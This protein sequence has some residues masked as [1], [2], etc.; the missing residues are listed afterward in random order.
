MKFVDRWFEQSTRFVARR[1]SRRNVLTRL[2]A[3]LL[4]STVLPT[5]PVARGEDKPSLPAPVDPDVSD[6]AG[7]PLG[8]NYW[9]HCAIDGYLCGCCGG[10]HSSCPPG[11]EMSPITWIGTCRNP[12]DGL[13]YIISYNDCC[14][15]STCNRCFCG[16]SEGEKPV[17]YAPKSANINWCI[18]T[19]TNIYH[20]STSVVIGRAV[21]SP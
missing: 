14:G 15:K 19:Q 12:V 5:L 4:G 16:R 1:V 18:G 7:D 8:C 21:E 17:Y 20:C 11:T 9:R 6:P 2:S 3:V 10:S 13:D